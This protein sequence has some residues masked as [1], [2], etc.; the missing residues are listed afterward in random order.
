MG[1]VLVVIVVAALIAEVV[2]LRLIARR[3]T[4]STARHTPDGSRGRE[5]GERGDAHRRPD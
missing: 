5:P 3:I 2:L 4:S 1:G